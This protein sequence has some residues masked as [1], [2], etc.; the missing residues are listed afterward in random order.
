MDEKA[1]FRALGERLRDMRT[2]RGLSQEK[3]I[4]CGFSPRHWK[5]I[6]AGRP[7]TLKTVLR[8][9]EVFAVPVA[10]LMRGLDKGMYRGGAGRRP[11]RSD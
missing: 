6:E 1:F 7:I 5:Q 11:P 4:F 9:C 2:R 10:S 3:M 8:I